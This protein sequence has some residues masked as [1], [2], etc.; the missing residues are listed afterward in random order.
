MLIWYFSDEVHY[1]RRLRGYVFDCMTLDKASLRRTH[2][3]DDFRPMNLQFKLCVT[4]WI[5]LKEKLRG[6]GRVVNPR[7][8]ERPGLYERDGMDQFY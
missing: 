8:L 2:G 5:R 1:N 3:R 4:Y 6:I 7:K